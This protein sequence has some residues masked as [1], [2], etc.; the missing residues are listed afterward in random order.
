MVKT[1]QS[2]CT[3]AEI[4]LSTVTLLTYIQSSA[5]YQKLKLKILHLV[6]KY[7][8]SFIFGDLMTWFVKHRLQKIQK[9][10][11]VWY[12]KLSTV[13]FCVENM[14][15]YKMYDYII[16]HIWTYILVCAIKCKIFVTKA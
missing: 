7:V 16:I 2:V 12:T 13:G 8:Y 5:T 14:L 1:P 3:F 10:Y 11:F 4:H 15:L 9:K 6:L